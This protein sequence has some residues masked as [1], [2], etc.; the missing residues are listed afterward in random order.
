MIE[1]NFFP[2]REQEQLYRFRWTIYGMLISLG[3]AV[4]FLVIQH[5]VLTYKLDKLQDGIAVLQQQVVVDKQYGNFSRFEISI[6]ESAVEKINAYQRGIFTL[7]AEL[8]ML[9][10]RGLCLSKVELKKNEIQILG[11]TRSLADLTQLMAVWE[12]E[13]WVQQIKLITVEQRTTTNHYFHLQGLLEKYPT[14][15][16]SYELE[17]D[18]IEG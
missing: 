8:H 13:Q 11:N 15:D 3:L 17:K 7:L 2:W 16:Q 10:Q 14:W 1:I 18:I 12:K 9:P 6:I 4:I 5:C